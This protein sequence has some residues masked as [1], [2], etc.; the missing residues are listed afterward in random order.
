MDPFIEAQE[1]D[2]FHSRFHLA[3]ADAIQPTLSGRY[4]VRVERRVVAIVADSGFGGT[5]GGPVDEAVA[6]PPNV[7]EWLKSALATTQ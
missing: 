3:V 4:F 5:T 1:W 2:D 6:R 7:Q